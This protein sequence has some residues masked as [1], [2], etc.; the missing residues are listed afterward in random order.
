MVLIE[1]E[2]VDYSSVFAF[3]VAYAIVGKG[4]GQNI[5]FGEKYY[6]NA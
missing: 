6:Y 5:N 1:L 2:S 3:M 4:L